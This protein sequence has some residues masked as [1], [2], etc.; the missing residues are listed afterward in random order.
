MMMDHTHFDAITRSFGTP[1]RR[2]LGRALAGG[3]FAA[4]FGSALGALDTDAKKKRHKRK[5][6]KRKHTQLNPPVST[7]PPEVPPLVFNQYG[8]I[9]VGQSCRGDSALCCS[10]ICQGAAPATGQPD[11][12]RCV[13]HDT[14]TCDQ[15][16]PGLCSAA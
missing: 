12:S 1:S 6:K 11:T 14:G 7:V 10:G 3:G 13:A 5:G 8:C 9:A 4:L 15:A 16:A 2:S